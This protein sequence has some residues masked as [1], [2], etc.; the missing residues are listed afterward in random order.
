MS[1]LTAQQSSA[2]IFFQEMKQNAEIHQQVQ[3]SE[4]DT[5]LKAGGGG[6][7]KKNAGAAAAEALKK[8]SD[9][10]QQDIHTLDFEGIGKQLQLDGQKVWEKDGDKYRGITTEF[11]KMRLEKEGK[12]ELTEKKGSPWYVNFAKEMTGFFSLLLWFGAFLCFIG[13]GIQKSKD[14]KSNLYLGIVLS[15]VVFITGCFSYQQSSKSAALMA[16]FKNFIPKACSTYRDG[17]VQTT[18][19][20]DLVRGDIVSIK[21]GDSIPA[22]LCMLDTQGDMKVDNSSLTGETEQLLRDAEQSS[23]GTKLLESS[24]VV[25][26]GTECKNGSGV[27][28]VFAIADKTVIGAI[29]NLAE[30]AEA[31]ETPLSI[32]IHRFILIV[33]SVA[34]FLGVTFFI[35]GVAYGYDIITNLVF[36]IGII[37]ANVPEGLLATVTVSLALTA[38]RMSKKFVLVK[39]LESV[40]TLGSTSCIC[41][42]KTGTLTQNIMTVSQL[43]FDLKRFDASI[44]MSEFKS[45]DEAMKKKFAG[46]ELGYDVNETGFKMLMRAVSL[47]TTASFT[48]NLDDKTIKEQMKKVGNQK[49]DEASVKAFKATFEKDL[50]NFED[51]KKFVIGDASETGLIKFNN[52]VSFGKDGTAGIDKC[53]EHFPE[54]VSHNQQCN[55]PFNSAIK[56]NLSIRNMQQADSAD[57]FGISGHKALTVFMKGAPERIIERC[58]K[59]LIRG[60]ERDITE[61]DKATIYDENASMGADGERVLAFAQCHL[62]PSVYTNEYEFKMGYFKGHKPEDLLKMDHSSIHG[63]F[64]MYGLTF[65]GLV[66]LNDPPRFRVDHSVDKCRK[67]GIKVIMV[68]GD[69]K[70][71]GAAI[72]HKVRIIRDLETTFDKLKE[73]NPEMSEKEALH[74][75]KSIVIHGDEL[76]KKFA[77]EEHMPD[78]APD[79][80]RYLLDWIRKDEIVFARTS[81]SQKL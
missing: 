71:T 79:K 15:T 54:H 21:N 68:T 36:A 66:S 33:S 59:I 11:A 14:D 40:E 60:E 41:S 80:G 20:G 22:D 61:G 38:Q 45:S 63:Y 46:R 19:A 73:K 30:Q 62:D 17:A 48:S 70:P 75:C 47:S 32:E 6:G 69:Q 18:L 53:R 78:D 23:A 35:F 55:I 1:K 24:R 37:V 9:S 58:S 42:D 81:P 26:S 10:Q 34:I 44:N 65:I 7:K 74:K 2:A 52:S 51:T 39:N 57:S 29:A 3:M 16:K 43:V 12:N 72:A 76:A 25:F 5:L 77:E 27:G 49:E 67:A 64:P 31:V 13:Y 50:E 56:F 8:A 28:I 4:V